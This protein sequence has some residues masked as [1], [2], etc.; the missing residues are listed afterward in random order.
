MGSRLPPAASTGSPASTSGG[1]GWA[2]SI[3][4]FTPAGHN[5]TGP[6]NACTKR[7][8]AAPSGPRGPTPGAQQRAFNRFR[9]EYNEERSHAS[10]G[11]QTPAAHYQA[12]PRPY[13][14]R[15]PPQEGPGH[16]LVKKITTGGTFRFQRQLL[17]LAHSLTYRPPHRAGRN[18]RR[19]RAR[20]PP[21]CSGSGKALSI[22]PLPHASWSP[23]HMPHPT[24]VMPQVK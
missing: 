22:P 17:F 4:A 19:L 18:R 20:V 3:S 14:R 13:P 2:F 1:C 7:S 9:T 10:V 8:S 16:F 11:G 21:T 15:L 23:Q 12:S 5:R 6:T 24:A